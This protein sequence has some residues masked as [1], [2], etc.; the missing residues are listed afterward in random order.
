A[1]KDCDSPC[2]LFV[3][4]G[5]QV[6]FTAN[7]APG[8][9]FNNWLID[10]ATVG[11][12]NTCALTLNGNGSVVA[13][14]S[15]NNQSALT[16]F[17]DGDASGTVDISPDSITCQPAVG[18]GPCVTLLTPGAGRSLQGQPAGTGN[19]AL[20]FAPDCLGTNPCVED[21]TTDKTV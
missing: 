15:T 13:T 7:P 8:K 10:C 21:L 19:L 17:F 3:E 16:I 4:S 18:G 9:I 5:T 20:G 1:S 2:D 14:S 6:T 12:G 11:V